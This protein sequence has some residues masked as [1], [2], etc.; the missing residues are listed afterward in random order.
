MRDTDLCNNL[1]EE[2]GREYDI[3]FILSGVSQID[4][5]YQIREIHIFDYVKLNI[6]DLTFG[7]P[8]APL[9]DL[10]RKIKNDGAKIIAVNVADAETLA[11]ST[12]FEV[13]YIHGYLV[14]KPY[15]DVISDGNG[16]LY[17]VA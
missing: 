9:Q 4:I 11:F 16:D 7:S 14:G 6:K 1:I 12:E 17:Y 10:I 5:Y 13:D 2:I 3:K 8:R 15:I